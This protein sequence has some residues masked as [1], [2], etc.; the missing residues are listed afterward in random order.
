MNEDQARVPAGFPTGGQFTVE[1]SATGDIKL[2]TRFE[3]STPTKY[4]NPSVHYEQ[5]RNKHPLPKDWAW[6]GGGQGHSMRASTVALKADGTVV[7]PA[8]LP[9]VEQAF[10][11]Q[12][13]HAAADFVKTLIK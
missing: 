9:H 2:V 12:G 1:P 13:E 10:R 11:R 7:N 3:H 6:E 5:E 8:A 4:E